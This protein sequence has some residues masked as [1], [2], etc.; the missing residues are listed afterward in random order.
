VVLVTEGN[1]LLLAEGDRLTQLYLADG[2]VEMRTNESLINYEG[3]NYSLPVMGNPFSFEEAARRMSQEDTRLIEKRWAER[4][5][6][7]PG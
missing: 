3:E 2:T 7:F 1:R 4:W 6:G 5:N